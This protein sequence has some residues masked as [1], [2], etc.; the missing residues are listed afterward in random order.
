MQEYVIAI[1]LRLSL[2]DENIGESNSISSQRCMLMDYIQENFSLQNIKVLEFC[3]D[4]YTGTNFDRPSMK[5]LL[6]LVKCGKVDCIVVKDL[7]RFGRNHIEVGDYLEQVFPFLGTRFISVNNSYDNADYS[8]TTSDLSVAFTSL[9]N[10]MYSKDLS[11]KVKTAFLTKQ[12]KG[13]FISPFA[14]YGYNKEDKMLVVDKYAASIVKRIFKLKLD[15]LTFADIARILNAEGVESPSVYKRSKD[16]GR[17]WKTMS[18][19][20]QIWRSNTVST[21]VRDRR[22][23]G[24]MISNKRVHLA[25][26]NKKTVRVPESEWIIV[27][28]THEAII[29]NEDFDK[30]NQDYKKRIY[31]RNNKSKPLLKPRCGYC[32]SILPGT[33]TGNQRYYC[34]HSSFNDECSKVS[35]SES[36]VLKVLQTSIN[37]MLKIS[38]KNKKQKSIFNISCDKLAKEIDRLNRE[39]EKCNVEKDTAYEQY[40][41]GYINVKE[42]KDIRANLSEKIDR[43]NLKKNKLNEQLS[44]NEQEANEQL[45]SDN[46]EK[47]LRDCIKNNHLTAEVIE[48][49]ISNIF[50]YSNRKIEIVWTFGDI[51]C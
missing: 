6:E 19:K 37:E 27:P 40:V 28:N 44:L 1:Y 9:A 46:T 24:V 32:N 39:L 50:I 17:T 51:M 8:G 22:Y 26:G 3:D 10:E 11:V 12:R 35:M 48:P 21:I 2:D 47:K 23:T 25:V 43:I 38:D 34:K 5:K 49:L 36:D 33:Y 31:N 14:I 20:T 16:I 41:D 4:G 13:E 45:K 15:G 7:S 42:Y 30:A 18:T 29:S